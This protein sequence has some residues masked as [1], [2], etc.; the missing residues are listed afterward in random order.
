M[1]EQ[2]QLKPLDPSELSEEQREVLAPFAER[3]RVLN[4]FATLAHHPKLLKRW[5]VFANHILSKSS[6]PPREREMAILRIGW[7]CRAEY[8]WGQ[9]VQIAKRSGL[10]DAEIARIS[11]GPAAPGCTPAEAALLRAVDELHRDAVIGETTWATLSAH[12]DTQQLLDLVFTVGNYNLV[13]MA[14]NTL[15]VRLDAG[16]PGFEQ[17]T[18]TPP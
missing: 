10:S 17:L 13:S 6:L 14:L 1:P 2:P 4:I 12:F 18:L 5:L 16:I 15:G 8:E 9:H 3:G 7:L 11:A